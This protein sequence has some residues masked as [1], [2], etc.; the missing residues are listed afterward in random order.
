[1]FLAYGSEAFQKPLLPD[2][3]VYVY[4]IGALLVSVP[5]FHEEKHKL[6]DIAYEIEIQELGVDSSN[7]TNG[8][9]V[10]RKI[11]LAC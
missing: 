1:M 3:S 5:R 10:V 2:N 11:M 7:D 4:N 9:K 6:Q 8:S